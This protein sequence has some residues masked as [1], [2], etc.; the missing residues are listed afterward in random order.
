MLSV[1]M[2]VE[3]PIMY[4]HAE[5]TDWQENLK[6][7]FPDESI[8]GNQEEEESNKE[9]EPDNGQESGEEVDRE[10]DIFEDDSEDTETSE[11][12]VS[13]N[14]I[15]DNSISQ[16]SIFENS[17][18]TELLVQ[19]QKA[20]EAFKAIIQDKELMALLYHCDTYDVRSM[21]GADSST[22]TT[23][24]VGT[25]L[26][27]RDVE[28]TRE[29]IWYYVAFWFN[30]EE[31]TGY[32]EE[33]YLAHA[34]EEWKAWEEEYLTG[35]LAN[36]YAIQ[37]YGVDYSDVEAFP[38][39]YQS[40]LRTLKEQH[41]NW[42]FVP[43]K[44]GIDFNTAV[45]NQMGVKS[46]IQKTNAN[47]QKGW[48]GSSCPSE[49]GWYYAT[50]SAVVYHLN[51]TNFLTVDS[52]FMFEQLTFNSSY[53]TESAVQSFL[54]GTFMSG[55]LADDSQGR[56]Y[57]Q[58]FYEIGKSRKLSPIHLAS[59]VYQEQG[60]GKSALISGTYSGYEGYYN[61]FNVGV[62]GSSNA[63]KIQK[64]LSYAK[65]KGWNTRYKSLEGG[66]ATIGNNYILKGQDTVYLEK[67]N[68]NKN[69]PYGLYN[70]QYMQNIQAPKSEAAS[71]KKMY[72]N[73]G[74]INAAFVFKIP[75][76]NNMPGNSD[77]PLTEIQMEKN[78]QQITQDEEIVLRRPDTVV[79]NTTGLSEEERATNTAQAELQVV[80]YPADTT[81]DKTIVWKSSNP[82]VATVSTG[83]DSS[84]CIVTA[85]TTGEVTITASASKAGN[86]KVTCKV[87]VTAP[88]YQVKISNLNEGESKE[89]AAYVGQNIN[90]TAEY[91]PK[92]TT[93]ENKVTWNSSNPAV[94]EVTDGKVRALAAGTTVI[95]ASLSG[96]QDSYPVIV[97]ECALIFMDK[98]NKT[99]LKKITVTYGE[100]ITPDE[101]PVLA[102][103]EGFTF[104]GW[105]T[106]A[107]GKGSLCDTAVRVYEEEMIL[108]P[109]FEETGKGFY[110][111]PVG[112][113]TY[114]G[115]AIKPAIQV[116]DDVTYTDGSRERITLLY[117]KDYT[118]SYRNNIKVNSG[119]KN[120]PTIVVTGKGNYAGKETI[121]FN[122]VPKALTDADISIQDITMAYTGK[123]IKAAPAV[124]WNGKKL[125]VNTDY[126][127]TY[128][129]AGNGAYQKA[130]VYP[131]TITGKDGYT[132]KVT[133]YQTITQEI[134]LSKVTIAK[135][136]NQQYDN[137]LVDKENGKGIEPDDLLVTYKKERLEESR[138]GGI[139][140]DYVVTYSNNMAIG[141]ATATISAVEGSGYT[142]SKSITYKIVGASLARAVVTG[143]TNKEYTGE[144][145]AVQ[146]NPEDIVLTLNGE[147]L[148][149]SQD[150]GV[151]GDYVISYANL[152]KAGTAT[153]IF[154]G[155]NGYT[156]QVKKTY[157]IV[158]H[159][160]GNG[161]AEAEE[162]FE[163]AY[164]EQG[165]EASEARKIACLNEIAATYVKGQT[166]PVVVLTYQGKVLQ[167]NKD[168]R[169]TYKNNS[170]VTTDQTP[171]KKLPQ[172][173]VTGAGNYTGK[174]TGTWK[175]T[176][177]A[178]GNQ[179][180]KLTIMVKDVVYKNRK[181][182]YKS[183]VV[184]TDVNGQRLQAGKDYQKEISYTYE[185][186]TS[187]PGT[188]GLMVVRNAGEK[189]EATDIPQAGTIICVTAVGMGP[190]SGNGGELVFA[191][192]RIVQADLS[193]ARVTVQAQEYQNG[194]AI[195][196]SQE[197]ITVKMQGVS[198]PLIYGQDYQIDMASYQKN[199]QKG[200]ASFVIR[201][202]SDS[203]YGGEKKATFRIVSKTL[204][205]W[206]N[207][208]S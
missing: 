137:V 28:I 47:T 104:E 55:K 170:G 107:E 134:F 184:I 189:V 161:S 89:G 83:E 85:V 112:D 7:E 111:V 94:A 14:S 116:Y 186:N 46:L 86:R 97:K 133:I 73:A 101:F 171:E 141:T 175:I 192:Y 50:E 203:S 74:S 150:N 43:M 144:T 200:T 26:Y 5:E 115:S 22:V 9:Q 88:V 199:T 62:N 1:L 90:L 197:D 3:Q 25:T 191:T 154:K 185:E 153:I 207:L 151:T 146:Q 30:G 66:A 121:T 166:K 202:V 63:E 162:G 93:S 103:T 52:I 120:V 33:N 109:Y 195:I 81:D 188:D 193:K 174:I 140:G 130:G 61:F 147:V 131:I 127:V 113:Q 34:D 139:T 38:A 204:V 44:T 16:N 157:R 180:A 148:E 42:T 87:R 49:N 29:N 163:L 152:T 45:K 160:I 196:L 36:P 176:D 71:T 19:M 179:D 78:G 82:K 56:T 57:A 68:V 59:R 122:I 118:V 64:G 100:Q 173:T 60:Q 18:D 132:G 169:I 69:S 10:E 6:E 168:Y 23:I 84:K 129:Q 194:R 54:R 136:P 70:H 124:M 183:N 126:T 31:V 198:A 172:I 40:A 135:I 190:Y 48:V 24:E 128:P 65:S 96:Y 91:L 181:N 75:V 11:K 53:H 20:K 72:T 4:I 158:A 117:N 165:Q 167:L 206:R 159:K 79:E 123:V 108:Y 15:S 37:T 155:V 98:D 8:S 99:Q 13:D 205:W 177:G 125:R 51:P 187:F 149:Q 106:Q 76:F 201:G 110:V 164:Y 105:Y 17:T 39:A 119:S 2:I 41:A 27:I 92:D 12:S 182:A 67:F 178:L 21:P 114:T 102:D 35:I 77:K 32:V 156:G 145:E 58:A 208:I 95:T 143:I 142:G 138:D 80:Y